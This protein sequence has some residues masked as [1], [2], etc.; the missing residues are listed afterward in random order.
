[1]CT[2]SSEAWQACLS[3]P[4]MLI[5][6]VTVGEVSWD[7]PS[8]VAP[9]KILPSDED[10]NMASSD[11]SAVTYDMVGRVFQRRSDGHFTARFTNP[12]N[13]AVY[14]YNDLAHDG[15]ALRMKNATLRTHLV[16]TDEKIYIPPGSCTAFV[17]YHLRG[18]T[19]AQK[20][21]F[22][23]Q[24]TVIEDVHKVRVTY[25][26]FG[27]LPTVSL[28]IP[29]SRELADE[30]RYWMSN[31]HST[32][33]RDY[34]QVSLPPS[35][36]AEVVQKELG[37]TEDPPI[38]KPPAQPHPTVKSKKKKK[39]TLKLPAKS[40][41]PSLPWNFNDD[42]DETEPKLPSTQDMSSP[43]RRSVSPFPFLCRCGAE[44]DGISLCNDE[45]AVQCYDCERWS[46][47][48]CQRNGWATKLMPRQKFICDHCNPLVLLPP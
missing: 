16:G 4:I 47:L 9:I 12:E 17:V 3:V 25:Q 23:H 26:R 10:D 6:H 11:Q 15:H 32:V 33:Y 37:E 5:V 28:N 29:Q 20:R 14:A 43:G 41:K 44:G 24:C 46:H 8:S 18:G 34:E 31:P 13:S 30:E 45:E 7:F 27:D 22:E 21:I 38:L 2:R 42:L 19:A 40:P 35:S 48:A 39:L 36:V 1:M